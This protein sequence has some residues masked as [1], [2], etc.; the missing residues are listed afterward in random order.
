[1]LRWWWYSTSDF[2]KAAHNLMVVINKSIV[3][4][5]WLLIL[6]LGFNLWPWDNIIMLTCFP[7]HEGF[8]TYTAFK[9]KYTAMRKSKI[10]GLCHYAF[11]SITSSYLTWW[12]MHMRASITIILGC[13]WNDLETME[14][15]TGF[16]K[17]H[18]YFLCTCVCSDIYISNW[19]DTIREII[20]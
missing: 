11:F 19:N 3:R 17:F 15:E 8:K 14:F 6:N 12:S 10:S 20:D 1:M 9:R 16:R 5:N 2:G 18:E 7:N 13:A 4:V